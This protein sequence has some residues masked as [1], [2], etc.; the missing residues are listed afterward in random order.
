MK[1]LNLSGS[2]QCD[3]IR[4]FDGGFD[5]K[6][7]TIIAI[8][9]PGFGFSRPP[10]RE[11]SPEAP[12]KDAHLAAKLMDKLGYKNYAI[13]GWDIG[14]CVALLMAIEYQARVDKLV[15][16]GVRAVM[17]DQE[18]E[19]LCEARDFE[20]YDKELKQLYTEMY[21]SDT[22]KTFWSAYVDYHATFLGKANEL[23]DVREEIGKIKCPTM[24]L[25]GDQDKF[26]EKE[27][28]RMTEKAI[29]DCRLVRFGNGTHNLHRDLAEKFNKTVSNFL[30]I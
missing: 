13:L 19:A 17:T 10:E 22:L 15:V 3:F 6:S 5:Q 24:V 8:D 11:L 1:S 12:T 29:P 9:L 25:H 28:P 20:N 16:W 2:A 4:Q 26:I 23:W 18:I 27:N 14:A 21:G 30:K 7:F